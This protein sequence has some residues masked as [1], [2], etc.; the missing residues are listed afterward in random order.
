MAHLLT[1]S[2]LYREAIDEVKDQ[3]VEMIHKHILGLKADGKYD[4][5]V[6]QVKQFQLATQIFDAFGESVDNYSVAGEDVR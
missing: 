1:M 6:M 2:N 5:L 3:I 4:D